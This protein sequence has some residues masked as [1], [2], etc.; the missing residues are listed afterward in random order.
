LAVSPATASYRASGLVP[1]HFPDIADLADDVCFVGAK[2][3]SLLRRPS[4]DASLQCDAH[5]RSHCD[6]WFDDP[7]KIVKPVGAELIGDG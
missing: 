4:S 3:T 5:A 2:R 6:D 7:A 1:W